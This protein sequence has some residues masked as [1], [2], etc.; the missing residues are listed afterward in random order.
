MMDFPI[1]ISKKAGGKGW[2]EEREEGGE[3]G[4]GWIVE[5]CGW[6]NFGGGKGWW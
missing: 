4:D 1:L 3:R 6:I 2:D 5:G